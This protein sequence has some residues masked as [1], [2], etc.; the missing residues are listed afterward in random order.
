VGHEQIWRNAIY[1]R[2]IIC[3]VQ[4]HQSAGGG[5]ATI[6][7]LVRVMHHLLEGMMHDDALSY[8]ASYY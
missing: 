5:G 3:Q 2:G 7:V 6:P 1:S 4:A 8:R